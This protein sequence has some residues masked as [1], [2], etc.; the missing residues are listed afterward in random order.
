[1]ITHSLSMCVQDYFLATG[2][3]DTNEASVLTCRL[4][5]NFLCQ[6]PLNFYLILCRAAIPACLNKISKS[7]LQGGGVDPW[8]TGSYDLAL[9]EAH[10]E[11]FNVVAY[12]SVIPAGMLNCSYP[13]MLPHTVPFV[14]QSLWHALETYN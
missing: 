2:A 7:A 1:M 6:V 8:E 5:C 10:I 4:T 11:D 14:G 3:G 13:G 12:T 9:E